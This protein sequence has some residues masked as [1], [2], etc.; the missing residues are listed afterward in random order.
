LAGPDGAARPWPTLAASQTVA[1]LD[2]AWSVTLGE[3]QTDTPLKSWQDLG[4]GSFAGT[5]D[6]R[7][8]F[9]PPA[10]PEPGRRVYLDLGNVGEIA[11]V[12]L[13]GTEFD[14][15]GWPPYVWDVT[16]SLK[17]GAN[18]I[19]VQVQ[20]PAEGG[21]GGGRARGA[22]AALGAGRAPGMFFPD[23]PPAVP[24]ARGLLG[25]VRLIAQ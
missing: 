3:R 16:D 22:A 5:A 17:S 21:R 2:G 6:Y 20:V 4:A 15:R 8:T 23:A 14:A 7:M 1:N 18:S 13:N 12:R 24:P 11:R 25:P 19:E 9:N 10:L